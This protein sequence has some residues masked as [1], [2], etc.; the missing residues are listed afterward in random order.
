MP[1]KDNAL[2][3]YEYALATGDD[4]VGK[5]M[6]NWIAFNWIYCKYSGGTDRRQIENLCTERQGELEGYNPFDD[7][8]AIKVFKKKPV[9]D[10]RGGNHRRERPVCPSQMDPWQL[11]DG[12]CNGDGLEKIQCLLLTIYQ[13]RCNLFHGSKEPHDERDQ[14][15]VRSS[16]TIMQGYMEALLHIDS[17]SRQ[18]VG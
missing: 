11:H 17:S 12:L 8:E 9:L 4:S 16:A 18:T 3:W 7:E 10:G 1:R 13:V 5:F 15:L 6:M 2:A 14:K